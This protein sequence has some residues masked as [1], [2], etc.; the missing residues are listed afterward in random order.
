MS[1]PHQPLTERMNRYVARFADLR[2]GACDVR[3]AATVVVEIRLDYTPVHAYLHRDVCSHGAPS[4][5]KG[6]IEGVAD[7]DS[8]REQNLEIERASR[9][10][11]FES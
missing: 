2:Q 3:R 11:V 9:D 1:E 4:I 7:F 10:A 8:E 5:P 6:G